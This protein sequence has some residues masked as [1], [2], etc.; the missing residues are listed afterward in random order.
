MDDLIKRLEKYRLEN[1]V[2]QGRLAKELGV[3]FSTVNRWLNDKSKPDKIQSYHIEKL[4]KNK[5]KIPK[6]QFTL[7]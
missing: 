3:A 2:S 6:K 4:I 1:K 5:V 7:F